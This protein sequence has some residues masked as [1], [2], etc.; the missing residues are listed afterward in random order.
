MNLTT[1]GLHQTGISSDVYSDSTATTLVSNGFNQVLS[2]V[3]ND[4]ANF[5]IGD[6]VATFDFKNTTQTG[7][8]TLVVKKD[9]ASFTNN[10]AFTSG[11][12]LINYFNGVATPTGNFNYYVINT[13][14][15][16]ATNDILLLVN[17]NLPGG[18]GTAGS[19]GSSGTAGSSGTSGVADILNNAN[20]R[21]TTA[22][23][24]TGELNAE[25][26][27]TFETSTL[28]VLST[29]SN[30]HG[31][32][33]YGGVNGSASPYLTSTG[34]SAMN[35][36]SSAT[37]FVL[38]FQRNK[39]AFDNDSTNTFIQADASNP[40]NLEI[41]A[42]GNIELQADNEITAPNMGTGADNSVVVKNTSNELVTDE[43]DSRVWGS[44]LVDYTGTPAATELAIFNDIDTIEGTSG[45]LTWD[46]T[47][48]LIDGNLTANE[49]NFDIPH[50]TKEGWRLRYSVLEGPERGVYIRGHISGS[51][52]IELPD[53]WSG[54]VY[55]DS[56]TVQLT[57]IGNACTHYVDNVTT[58]SI[59]IGC[60]CN[61]INAYFVV[62]AERK[63]ETPIQVE[64]QKND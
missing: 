22:T 62:H 49:K 64:Y 28:S 25:E 7:N 63:A 6:I 21:V 13:N 54:L 26:K 40:E 31:I 2:N 23:G 16:I 41:H 17:Y 9:N 10:N 8:F 52:T 29:N 32:V 11:D 46:G 61:E 55:E 36:G 35:F 34:F 50:P 37:G 1:N 42:D 30:T 24:T 51:N 12:G 3:A 20:N 4:W 38:D 57:P 14:G 39:I 58:T 56:I 19:S 45:R 33:I 59:S 48:L 43:I 47:E 53:Y 15:N 5:S 18:T 60:S 44:S 27:L